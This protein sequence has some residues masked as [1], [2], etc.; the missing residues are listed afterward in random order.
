MLRH[1]V[2]LLLIGLGVTA[3]QTSRAAG[4]PRDSDLFIRPEDQHTTLFGGLDAGRSVFVSGGSK[5]T[6]TGPLDRPGFVLMENSGYGLTQER[7]R[8]G[9]G[10][11][12]VDRL[13][14]DASLALG[15]QTMFGPAYLA[16]FLGPELH[17]EQVAYGGRF[18]RLATPLV[19]LR[20]Q[21][22]LWIN[23]S[24]ETLV[25]G[26]VVAGTAQMSVWARGSAGL[27]IAPGT[28][29]GP[30]ITAYATP[31]YSEVRWGGHV[32]GLTLGLVQL[33]VSAGWMTDDA[34]RSGS[35]Y[36]GISAWMRL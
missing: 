15:Y 18:R 10:S 5:Q 27:R 13:K 6:L 8:I 9:D 14:H 36:A 17:Q 2:L 12:L 26:T 34:H 16:G 25:T 19:G 11:M 33:R 3:L 28:F 21:V 24:P 23:P 29:V 35:P 7:A 31:T 20:G 1:C 30:E 22:E 32:T 4:E